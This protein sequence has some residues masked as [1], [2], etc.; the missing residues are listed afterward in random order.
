MTTAENYIVDEKK[1]TVFCAQVGTKRRWFKRKSSI[2]PWVAKE[3]MF[4]IFTKWHEEYDETEQPDGTTH[5]V[6]H[7]WA[8]RKKVFIADL[9]AH[10]LDYA[11]ERLNDWFDKD[12][13]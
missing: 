4:N 10:D 7:E 5:I 2:L 8:D 6:W 13:V 12:Y 1:V 11:S 3:T 9:K